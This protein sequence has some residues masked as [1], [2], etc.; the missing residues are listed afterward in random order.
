MDVRYFSQAVYR[1]TTN[2]VPPPALPPVAMIA[3][4]QESIDH[5]GIDTD[6]INPM[7]RTY[8]AQLL[9]KLRAA[10]VKTIGLDYLLDSPDQG[11][12]A[13]K[14][15]VTAIQQRGT[16]IVFASD[17]NEA[18]QKIRPTDKIAT[19]YEILFGNT[20]FWGWQIALP[21]D[22]TCTTQ[23][24][25]FAYQLAVAKTLQRSL[26]LAQVPQPQP[27]S[28]TNSFQR[29]VSEALDK[30]LPSNPTEALIQKPNL[31]LGMPLIVDFSLPPTR[32]YRR[33]AAWELLEEKLN[34]Q[35]RRDLRNQIVIIAA[36]GY[37][38]ADD[39]EP[40]PWAIAYWRGTTQRQP[41]DSANLWVD[42]AEQNSENLA[43][44]TIHAYAAHHLLTGHL[45]RLIPSWW[46]IVLAAL[47]G[48]GSTLMIN[49]KKYWQRW[50]LIYL[51]MT[52]LYGV[53]SL[54]V[55]LIG[56]M[57]LPWLFP[58]LAF[59]SMWSLGQRRIG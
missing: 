38:R 13:L 52:L 59:W 39:N 50:V 21:A 34:Q 15:A 57:L 42:K 56:G 29:D 35:T 37:D 45:I 10:R 4:D 40:V 22:L 30:M 26:P 49:Q 53:V 8:L 7:D 5:A 48:K 28:R 33:I 6:N 55:Y 24:C 44:G 11:D 3:I 1:D 58:V 51:G 2:R 17:E 43:L 27:Q 14:K 32:I 41:N 47:A 9:N 12:A 46:M 31:P 19:P 18:G 54:E 36:D 20:I 23:D 16:W 25:P